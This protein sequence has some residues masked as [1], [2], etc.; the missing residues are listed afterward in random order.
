MTRIMHR[1]QIIQNLGMDR[2]RPQPT[3]RI[4]DDCLMNSTV[5]YTTISEKELH[6][7]VI[8]WGF[9]ILRLMN[10]QGGRR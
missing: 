3:L 2:P 5:T 1:V 10:G 6:A 4:S 9:E 8:P 7:S